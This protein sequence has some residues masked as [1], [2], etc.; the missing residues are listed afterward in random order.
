MSLLNRM[1]EWLKARKKDNG[2]IKEMLKAPKRYKKAVAESKKAKKAIQRRTWNDL[3][4]YR[5]GD[6]DSPDLPGSGEGIDFKLV[7]FLEDASL[8]WGKRLHPNSGV[9]TQKHN[10]KAKGKKKSEHLKGKGVDISCRTSSLRYFILERAFRAGFI[11]IGIGRTFIHI[12]TSKV[13]PQKVAWLYG[14]K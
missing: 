13:L 4:H 3:I 7:L 5:P 12:G 11:R 14:K 6:F 1:I 9:R 2:A 10:K 8:V